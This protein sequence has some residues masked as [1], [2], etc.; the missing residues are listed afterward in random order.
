[1]QSGKPGKFKYKR[2]DIRSE[3]GLE[4]AEDLKDKGWRIVSVGWDTVTMEKEK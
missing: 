1:M 4:E 2:I 3:K